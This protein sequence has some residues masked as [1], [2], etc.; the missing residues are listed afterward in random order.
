MNRLF[1]RGTQKALGQGWAGQLAVPLSG[2]SH[3]RQLTV[4]NRV[5]Q[6]VDGPCQ[7]RLSEPCTG[8]PHPQVL[9]GHGTL[10]PEGPGVPE[11]AP[12]VHHEASR[13]SI[14]K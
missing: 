2:A 3:T 14:G 12:L 1:R 10:V 7:S 11:R 9:H 8:A 4:Q 5:F 6:Y 13:F